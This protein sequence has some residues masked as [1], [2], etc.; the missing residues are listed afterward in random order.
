KEGD[1][2]FVDE[3]LFDYRKHEGAQ[4]T[5]LLEQLSFV[6]DLVRMVDRYSEYVEDS[7]DQ[8]NATTQHLIDNV[9]RYMS[10]LSNRPQYNFEAISG[11]RD[12]DSLNSELWS[13]DIA[14]IEHPDNL[15]PLLNDI[16]DFRRI[17]YLLLEHA[18]VQARFYRE[19]NQENLDLVHKIELL[20]GDIAAL[21][22]STS[23]KI[24]EPLRVALNRFR[25]DEST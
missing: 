19:L 2:E 12:H 3:V 11:T 9:L 10:N 14:E 1:L 18:L 23:W 24:T 17:T 7:S 8:E 22:S 25:Q 16:H 20:S 6:P 5:K 15:S 21:H 13:N 4:T